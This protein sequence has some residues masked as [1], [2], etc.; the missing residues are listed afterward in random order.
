[1]A[2]FYDCEFVDPSPQ[3]IQTDCPV[4]LSVL[5][6]P[7]QATCC[8]YSFCKVCI[9]QVIGDETPCPCCKAEDFD[10][11]EDKRLRRSLYALK[12]RCSNNK[13]GCPWEGELGQLE[14]H[15]N[16]DPQAADNVTTEQLEGCPF[17]ELKCLY[18]ANLFKRSE[19]QRHQSSL[20]PSR[21]TVCMYCDKYCSNNEDVTTKHWSLCAYY[22]VHCPNE[23]GKIL[24]RQNLEI[25][26]SST[27]PLAE[28]D[29]DFSDVG[30]KTHL[31]QK[32]MPSHLSESVVD[33]LSLMGCGHSKLLKVVDEQDNVLKNLMQKNLR[34]EQRAA[35]LSQS[36]ETMKQNNVTL[37][38]KLRKRDERFT[39]H[40]KSLEQQL[41]EESKNGRRE[42]AK[43]LKA[44]KQHLLDERK[45]TEQLVTQNKFPLPAVVVIAVIVVALLVVVL[46][47]LPSQH[48]H[49]SQP[50][51]L[52]VMVNQSNFSASLPNH[53][54]K[55]YSLPCTG[56][57]KVCLGIGMEN[58]NGT[59]ERT[60][61]TLFV[62][63]HGINTNMEDK[64]LCLDDE[65]SV[66][67]FSERVSDGQ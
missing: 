4:C 10:V 6:D 65:M 48:N 41:E 37:Q 59:N 61:V 31:L 25:H 19:I 2:G 64:Q 7:Y 53:N 46:R 36:L 44:V 8:G 39:Q 15:F 52:P 28:I 35:K 23:C 27:C 62:Q 43:L 18:C 22:P 56:E 33:H 12:V 54:I 14:E 24:Q 11:F 50:Q 47:P 5:R 42:N 45:K 3:A 21:P 49:V 60:H 40:V 38:Q 32:D 1:M 17:V 55:W 9:E 66:E 29:C 20:C 30:C 13:H 63:P 57:C 34:L 26:I 16:A 58:G 51:V 67:P